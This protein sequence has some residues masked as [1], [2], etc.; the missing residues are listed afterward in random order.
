VS[1]PAVC[2]QTVPPLSTMHAPGARLGAAG[3]DA[4]LALLGTATVPPREIVPCRLVDSGSTGPVPM[5]LTA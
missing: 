2:E 1:T 4:L 3:V 5:A